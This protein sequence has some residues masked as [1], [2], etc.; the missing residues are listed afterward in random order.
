MTTNG[1]RQRFSLSTINARTIQD[2][3]KITGINYLDLNPFWQRIYECWKPEEHTKLIETFLLNRAMN[4][5]WTVSHPEE[6]IDCVLDG[7][8]R[9]KTALKFMRNEFFIT[10]KYLDELDA[11]K[12]NKK[13]FKDLDKYDRE[14]IK[15]Y[16]CEFN[17]LGSIYY[18]DGRKRRHMYNILNRSSKP[19]NEFEYLKVNYYKFYN[20]LTNHK[21][22]F[23]I[24]LTKIK[25]TRGKRE[26]EV[27]DMYILSNLY[28]IPS[29]GSLKAYRE[30]WQKKNFNDTEKGV[31]YYIET[32]QTQMIEKL[33]LLK[34]IIIK[35][36]Q[37]NFF[38]AL[39]KD[40]YIIYKF[41]IARLAN[42]FKNTSS[43]N[44]KIDELWIEF[45]K[46]ISNEDI[47]FEIM[48]ETKKGGRNATWQKCLL[49]RIDLIID[50]KYNPKNVKYNRTFSK[51]DIQLKY[52][53]QNYLCNLCK[54]NHTIDNIQGD[55]IIEYSKGG[56]TIYDN[57]QVLCIPCH[58]KKTAE[59]LKS[60]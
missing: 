59:F 14:S 17:L 60:K 10:G 44:N 32:H 27:L 56:A 52:K 5:I 46:L 6:N 50:S 16:A 33:T 11:N 57:L 23:D 45:Y 40:T 19:L 26:Y 31:N 9:L 13:F 51:S 43:L 1:T 24:F 36:N 18:V 12:Y 55:H 4:P 38:D 53:E 3:A 42:K 7:M 2:A 20:I 58:E 28:Y 54:K 37:R 41:I 8:H 48:G 21:K 22:G 25:D 29:W 30:L 35:F 39:N 34:K 49:E 47:V 15:N